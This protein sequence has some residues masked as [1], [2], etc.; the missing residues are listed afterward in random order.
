[1]DP[2]LMN[3]VIER[4]KRDVSSAIGLHTS[5]I[6]E[7]ALSMYLCMGF[8]KIKDIPQIHGVPY[9]TFKLD[10]SATV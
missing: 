7:I 5:H 9:S 2:Q 3:E 6:M 10:L 4:A 1:M 8:E